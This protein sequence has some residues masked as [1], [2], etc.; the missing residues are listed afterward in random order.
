MSRQSRHAGTCRQKSV[1]FI[2]DFTGAVVGFPGEYS[3]NFGPS[4]SGQLGRGGRGSSVNNVLM[5]GI[6]W[7]IDN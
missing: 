5:G 2:L 6:W 4:S 7:R 1:L 3:T